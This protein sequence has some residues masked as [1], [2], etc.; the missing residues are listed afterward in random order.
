MKLTGTLSRLLFSNES[1]MVAVLDNGIKIAGE[2]PPMGAQSL[3]G[4]AVALEGE[5]EEHPKFGPQFRFKSLEIEGSELYFFLTKVV[6]GVGKKLVGRLI[7]TYGEKELIRLLDEEPQK[8]LGFKGIKEKKLAQITESWRKW[9]Q[10]RALAMFLAPYK[11]AQS[12]VT[13]IYRAFGEGEDVI[14]RIRQNPYIITRIKGVGFRRADEMALSMGVDPHS[15]FRIE[16]AVDYVLREIGEGQG[17]S[18]VAP[19]L[20]Y[21]E[22]ARAL[23][24]EDLS[25]TPVERVLAQM[26]AQGRL[27]RVGEAWA[28]PLYYEAEA[29]LYAFFKSRRQMAGEP[30][31]EDIDA[32]IAREEKRAGFSLG[33]EQKEAVC[34]LNSGVRVMA[35][36]GYAGTGKS[37]ASR[38]LLKL[39]EERYGYEN[40]MTTALSGI[41]TRRIR[42]AT[43]YRGATIQSLLTTYAEAPMPF[44]V[45]L[46]DEASMVNAR[47]F[48]RLVSRL[49]ETA[50]LIVVGDDGQLPPIG[51]GDT[52]RDIVKYDLIP[53]VKLTKIYRQSEEQAIALI[54]DSIRRGRVPD[55][56]R[57]YG[58]FRLIMCPAQENYLSKS[59]LDAQA[60]KAVRERY[61]LAIL[62][63]LKREAASYIL[64]ARE[65]LSRK[66]IGAYVT[67]WQVITPMKGGL[68]G[69]EE[70]NRQLQALANPNPR[71]SVK[72]GVY[73][74]ALYDKV[75]HTRNENMPAWSPEAFKAS[76]D[77]EKQRIFNGMIGMIF[78]ID[79]EEE[80]CY[81][82]YPTEETVVRYGFEMLG[83]Y[84]AP[85]YALTV[86]KT[87]GMEYETVLLPMTFSHYVM[88]NTK[89]LYTA[90]TRAKKMCLVIGEKTAFEGACRRVDTAVRDT[91]LQ[92]L[93]QE[94]R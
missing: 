45:L 28:H 71:Q 49:K 61:N 47:L 74:F 22:L 83:E 69:T 64:R 76:L 15:A 46:L 87:Q 21:E 42:E 55:L 50:V 23:A 58:D 36:V 89:L 54:A 38:M 53:T 85:A 75:V 84:L 88:L 80:H 72:R 1:H 6:K 29:G 52:L 4:Q 5:W 91:V 57:A 31:T 34:L 90:V 68:L 27:K 32:F 94:K 78:K 51:A 77:A 65:H 19:A 7:E 30:L 33:E 3:E 67:A 18:A 86:H 16:A 43:G 56:D 48:Y 13:E 9:R 2:V 63:R 39:L 70:L 44:D 62:E 92:K 81:V 35:L 37:T 10:L 26:S 93:A 8:L 24:L 25:H 11:I 14:A 17:S 59:Q 66:E 79:E 41:A 82:Y 20:L 60:R 73:T 12:V 40:I